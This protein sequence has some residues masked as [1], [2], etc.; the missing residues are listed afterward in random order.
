MTTPITQRLLDSIIK[1]LTEEE[2]P[3]GMPL[4]NFDLLSSKVKPCDVL[5]VEGR[6]RCSEVI[7]TITQ[8]PWS[9]SVL[10][11][12]RLSETEDPLLRQKIM[13]Y[14]HG[15]PDEQLILEAVLGQ[16]TILSPLSL[17]RN[18][19]LRICRPQ[20]ISPHDAIKVIEHLL[21]RLGSDYD[22]RQI[23]DLAR[24]LLPYGILP[25]QWRSTLFA[26]SAGE[27]T[28][29]VCSSM[30][31]LAFMSVSFPILPVVQR[32][33]NGQIRLYRRN[34]RLFT[35]RDFDHSPYFEIIKYPLI[36]HDDL[37][38]YRNLPWDTEGIVCNSVNFCHLPGAVRD[39]TP[40]DLLWWPNR[41]FWL[42]LIEQLRR[43]LP[44]K[45][46]FPF[47]FLETETLSPKNS[48]H[49]DHHATEN[50]RRP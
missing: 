47:H 17:Y 40:S 36:G 48:V 49:V 2:E 29:T 28:R 32:D 9:H 38:N 24:F 34:F 4:C 12:G 11:I 1:W 31:A 30:L 7:K 43:F 50:G 35:P 39:K 18:H 33:K 42:P 10:Y 20:A 23:L 37:A 25:R 5:L 19:H 41:F 6:S 8:S 16:G 3:T 45:P 44:K 21:N 13:A 27:T 15:D 22:L 26:H 14:H 46:F